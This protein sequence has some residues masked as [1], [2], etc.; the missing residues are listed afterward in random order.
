MIRKADLNDMRSILEIYSSAKQFMHS[1]GNPNQWNGAYPDEQTLSC[2]IR[3]G[4][5]FVM[6]DENEEF[7]GCFALIGGEDET[8]AY[9]EGRWQSDLPYGTIHRI[10]GNG[11]K[12]GVFK[13]CFDFASKKY[14]H[15]RVDTHEDNLPMQRAVLRCGFEY[16]GVIYLA[17]GSPRLAYDWC[18]K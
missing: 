4:N 9:I 13:E 15:V 5:L 8:Y 12:R 1:N 3:N 14:N 18:K 17:D 6:L 2:D 11:T 16:A 10:A 7:Y